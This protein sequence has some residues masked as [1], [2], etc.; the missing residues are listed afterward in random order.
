MDAER[1]TGPLLDDATTPQQSS[2]LRG[3]HNARFVLHL[4]CL[5]L[6]GEQ[7]MK[8]WAVVGSDRERRHNTRDYK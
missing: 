2:D 7:R 6:G 8:K 3:A 4:L 1:G 5:F